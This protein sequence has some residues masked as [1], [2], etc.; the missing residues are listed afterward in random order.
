MGFPIRKSAGRSLFA[1]HRSLSQLV[2]SFIGSW[3][4]GIHLVLFLVYTLTTSS[5][6]AVSPFLEL[7]EF[8]KTNIDCSGI[9]SAAKRFSFCAFWILPPFGEIVFTQIWKDQFLFWLLLI[10]Q[11]IC[12]HYLFV[13]TL[14]FALFGFQ[15]TQFALFWREGVSCVSNL[16][17]SLREGAQVAL[18]TLMFSLCENPGRSGWTRTIDLALIRRAL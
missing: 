11:K 7:L 1:A 4:Q 17:L 16:T 9:H 13:S 12:P 5:V 3:C 6:V 8:L 15:W 10:S 2:A 18:A 14:T